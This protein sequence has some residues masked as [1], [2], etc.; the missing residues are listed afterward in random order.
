MP[1]YPSN[2]SIPPLQMRRGTLP[3]ISN[4]VPAQGELVVSTSTNQ[5]YVGDGV[6]VGGWLISGN[7]GNLDFGSIT[8]PAGFSLDLGSIV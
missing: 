6:T 4:Y 2:F 5:L 3:Q 1:I 7:G 8:A